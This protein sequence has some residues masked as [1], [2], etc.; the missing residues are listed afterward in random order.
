MT[1]RRQKIRRKGAARASTSGS[2]KSAYDLLDE[3]YIDW[4]FG[5]RFIGL[6]ADIA[7]PSTPRQVGLEY[8]IMF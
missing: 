7:W 3:E 8:S 2:P 1:R 4:F 6:P 5:A